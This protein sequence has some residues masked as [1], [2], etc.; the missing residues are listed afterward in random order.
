LTCNGWNGISPRSDGYHIGSAVSTLGNV[1]VEVVL[2]VNNISRSHESISQ[3]PRICI[4]DSAKDTR[5]ARLAKPG[6]VRHMDNLCSKAKIDGS[7]FVKDG[8]IDLV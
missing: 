1:N 5:R 4:R 3:T 8:A 2:V 7:R 6:R